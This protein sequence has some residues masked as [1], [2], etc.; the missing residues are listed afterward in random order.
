MMISSWG[1]LQSEEFSPLH[2]LDADTLLPRL[3]VVDVSC[4]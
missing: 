1:E 2:A 4:Q 3:V